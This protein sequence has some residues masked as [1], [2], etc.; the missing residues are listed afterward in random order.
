MLCQQ[1][2]PARR[3]HSRPPFLLR[4]EEAAGDVEPQCKSLQLG[5]FCCLPRLISFNYLSPFLSPSPSQILGFFQVMIFPPLPPA[6]AGS[7]CLPAITDPSAPSIS[8]LLFSTRSDHPFSLLSWLH[9]ARLPGSLFFVLSL[10]F[11]TWMAVAPLRPI[12]GVV[13]AV[14]AAHASSS[15]WDPGLGWAPSPAAAQTLVWSC[16]KALAPGQHHGA[17]VPS[18]ARVSLCC[19][20][21]PHLLCF[22]GPDALFSAADAAGCWEDNG[23]A[24]GTGSPWRC[25]VFLSWA[26]FPLQH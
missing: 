14:F 6:V 2:I 7:A 18:H 1:H 21:I 25:W 26:V 17:P 11:P 5:L 8:P 22:P 4:Q 13:L 20:F 15:A 16:Y 12:P 9:P 24:K 19:F 23:A 10:I 3:C